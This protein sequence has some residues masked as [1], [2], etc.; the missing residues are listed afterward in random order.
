MTTARD[1][2]T[3]IANHAAQ[4]QPPERARAIHATLG[5][6][7]DLAGDLPLDLADAL[8]GYEI[9]SRARPTDGLQLALD[10]KV[11][12]ELAQICRAYTEERGDPL[13]LA[14]ALSAVARNIVPITDRGHAIRDTCLREAAELQDAV[15]RAKSSGT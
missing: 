7:A 3:T 9:L 14:A 12:A 15:E 2:L 11:Y 13:R 1:T 6:L 10:R 5:Q 8:A 4:L